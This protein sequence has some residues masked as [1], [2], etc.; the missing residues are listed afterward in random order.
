MPPPRADPRGLGCAL[1]L[2]ILLWAAV[3]VVALL[4]MQALHG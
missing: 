4:A 1:L 3:T 2:G